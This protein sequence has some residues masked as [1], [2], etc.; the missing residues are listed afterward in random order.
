MIIRTR[1]ELKNIIKYE[2]DL[3]FKRLNN[4]V[5][6]KISKDNLVIIQ[7]FLKL[8]RIE[9]YFYTKCMKNSFYLGFYILSRRKKNNY[10]RKL[11]FYIPKNVLDE[12]AMI[13]HYG[14][15]VINEKS[16]IG[17]NC[18]LHGNN[19][20]GNNGIN[21]DKAPI[22]G[23]NADIGYGACVIGDVKLGNNVTIGA[24]AIVVHSFDEDNITLVGCPAKIV[25]K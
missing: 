20:I 6:S 7:R 11:G 23:D 17:K 16:K 4:I 13:Y 18:K 12:G 21:N 19:C 8:L 5:A 3:Y 14:D 15:I 25:K 9:E 24:G 2:K 10:G 1:R 22:I